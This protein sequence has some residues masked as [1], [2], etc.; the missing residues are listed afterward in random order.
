M[1]AYDYDLEFLEDGE[2]ISLISIGIVS[3]DGRDYYAVNSQMPTARIQA[4][5]WL[6]FNVVP[7]LPITD[8]SL[9]SIQNRQEH[10]ENLFPRPDMHLEL[11][12]RNTRVKPEFVIANEVRDFLLASAD[13]S[14]P[15]LWA[16]YG[17]YDHVCLMQLWGSMANLPAGIP[18]YTNDLQQEIRRLGICSADLPPQQGPA[19]NALADARYNQQVRRFLHTYQ[20][21]GYQS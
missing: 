20:E 2:T 21:P 1:T 4:H 15:V 18:M 12:Y 19:H 8:A 16:N 7:H 17:A 13:N 3:S 6:M 9:G 5:T 14:E 10:G 11:D